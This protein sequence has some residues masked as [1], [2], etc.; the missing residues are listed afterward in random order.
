[1]AL[2]KAHR[3]LKFLLVVLLAPEHDDTNSWVRDTLLAPEVLEFI[4]DPQNNM[5]VWGGNV[6]DSEAYQVANSLRVTKFPFAAVVVHTPNVSSTAMSVVGRIA[7]ITSSSEVVNKLRTVVTSNQEPIE[8]LR[9]S[10]AEQ[11]ASRS[12]R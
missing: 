8:R 7:G 4:N 9:S 5:L 10:R 1:M 11:Q 6:Q 2:E 3:D 12:L